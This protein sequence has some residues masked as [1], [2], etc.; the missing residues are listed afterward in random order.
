MIINKIKRPIRKQNTTYRVL[1]CTDVIFTV[2]GSENKGTSYFPC[3][4]GIHNMSTQNWVTHL[5]HYSVF[6][7]WPTY[8]LTMKETVQSLQDSFALVVVF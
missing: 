8:L 2:T 4:P 7:Q 3:G 1:K 6:S 5:E